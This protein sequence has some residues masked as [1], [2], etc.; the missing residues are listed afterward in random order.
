MGTFAVGQVVIITFPFSDL[1]STKTRPALILASAERNDW[2]CLQIT[3]RAYSDSAA[4][5]LNDEDFSTGSLQRR[6]FI[7]PGKLFTAHE[8]LFKRC[9]GQ[10]SETKLREVRT[11]VITLIQ[12]GHSDNA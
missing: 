7:R 5:E 10:I 6:S 8:S 12:T 11:A 2:L 3:S 4:I 9:A 1:S